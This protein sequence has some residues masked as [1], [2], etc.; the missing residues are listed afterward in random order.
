MIFALLQSRAYSAHL[1]SH[2][3]PGRFGESVGISMARVASKKEWKMMGAE[4]YNG[5]GK[6][7]NFMQPNLIAVD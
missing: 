7:P 6:I 1:I 2:K 5:Y 3:D 4:R